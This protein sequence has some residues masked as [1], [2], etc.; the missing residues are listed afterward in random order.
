MFF[1]GND[2]KKVDKIIKQIALNNRIPVNDKNSQKI[3]N[4]RKELHKM[5]SAIL[6]K[7]ARNN[8]YPVIKKIVESNFIRAD[9]VY[10]ERHLDIVRYSLVED[11]DELFKVLFYKYY[12]YIQCYFND[13]PT[14]LTITINNKNFD[15]MEIF[16]I[17]ESLYR[18]L[19]QKDIFLCFYLAVQENLE[20]IIEIILKNE[21]LESKITGEDLRKLFAYFISHKQYGKLKLLLNYDLLISKFTDKYLHSVVMLALFNKNIEALT[22]IMENSIFIKFIMRN[23]QLLDDIIKFAYSNNDAKIL[24]IILHYKKKL[25]SMFSNKDPLDTKNDIPDENITVEDSI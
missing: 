14:L 11:N 16:L 25:D 12:R 22:I 17:N 19:D 24:S 13:S 4:R 9:L 21:T 5:I 20:N 18:N 3:E 2:C 10:D 1:I 6:F 7:A 23:K 8:D 15:L